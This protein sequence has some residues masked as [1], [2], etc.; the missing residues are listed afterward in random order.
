[1]TN[2]KDKNGT[3][4]FG[5]FQFDY[6][7]HYLKSPTTGKRL[8]KKEAEVL[9]MLCMNQN[10]ILKRE[11]ALISIWGKDDYFMGRSMDVYIT[12]LR[13]LLKADPTVAITNIHNVGFMLEVKG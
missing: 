9:K 4:I 8:T 11:T 12:K 13:K 5:V 1:M 7:N 2:L 3:Y 10:N 6:N